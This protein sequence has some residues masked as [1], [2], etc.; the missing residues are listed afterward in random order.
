M[1]LTRFSDYALRVLM[2]AHSAGDRHVTIAEMAACYR[3]SRAHLMKVVNALTRSGYLAA[4]RGRSGGVKLARPAGEIRLGDVVRET[5]PDFAMVEC[6]SGKG[7]C[8][9][10]ASCGLP[11]VINEALDAFI[12]SLNRHTLESV[13]PAAMSFDPPPAPKS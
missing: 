11:A 1:Q 9:I 8:V 7:S 5:E 2:Y 3:I 12:E 13:T 6:M 10:A 4:I